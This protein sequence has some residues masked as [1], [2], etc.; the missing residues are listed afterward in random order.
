MTDIYTVPDSPADPEAA[1]LEL[2]V[3]L[4]G[5]TMHTDARLLHRC[6]TIAAP[7]GGSGRGKWS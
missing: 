5:D 3:R 1:A 7:G 6:R 4:P 2:I